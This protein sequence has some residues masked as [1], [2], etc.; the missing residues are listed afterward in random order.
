VRRAVKVLRSVALA[1]VLVGSLLGLGTQSASAATDPC[2]SSGYVRTA[3]GDV[4]AAGR[5]FHPGYNLAYLNSSPWG[6]SNGADHNLQWELTYQS[7][8]RT[9]RFC[10]QNLKAIGRTATKVST[11]SYPPGGGAGVTTPL[12]DA[13]S[14]PAGAGWI[15]VVSSHL[16]SMAAYQVYFGETW[17]GG[18]IHGWSNIVLRSYSCDAGAAGARAARRPDGVT[19][20]GC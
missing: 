6:A 2:L 14:I 7:S 10:V 5:Y 4:G 9:V 19:P 13:R 3:W 1:V 12:V 18:R 20:A 17:S 11:T 15:T 8:T 16:A